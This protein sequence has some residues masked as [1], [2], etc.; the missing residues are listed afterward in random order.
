VRLLDIII[1]LGVKGFQRSET[2]TMVSFIRDHH[3]LLVVHQ[4]DGVTRRD[5]AAS[6]SFEEFIKAIQLFLL[7]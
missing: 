3:P 2:E 1:N 6:L 5:E 7:N 4:M